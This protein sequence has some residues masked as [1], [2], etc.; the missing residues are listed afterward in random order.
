MINL[1]AI[2]LFGDFSEEALQDLACRLRQCQYS[3]GQT[4]LCAGDAPHEMHIVVQGAVRVELGE[5]AGQSRRRA[6][7][8]A[9]HTFGEMSVLSGNPVSATVV[10]H[11]D[12]TTLA[13]TAEDLSLVLEKEPSLYRRI[14]ALLIERLRHR[15]Q[16]FTS[17]FSSPV[18]VLVLDADS[19][20]DSAFVRAIAKG[21]AHYSPGSQLFDARVGDAATLHARIRRWRNEGSADHFLIVV[22]PAEGFAAVRGMLLAGDAVLRVISRA[23]ARADEHFDAGPADARTVLLDL[24]VSSGQA[25]SWAEAVSPRELAEC[26]G[27]SW[28]RARYP[29]ID[30]LAR[31]ITDREVGVAMSVGAAAG[32]AHLGFLQVLQDCGVPIDFICGSSMGGAVALGFGQ[33][34]EASKAA[35]ALCGLGAAFAKSRGLQMVPRAALVAPRRMQQIADEIFGTRTFAEL[36]LPV[37]VVAADLVAGQRVILDRGPVAQA[38]R[39]TVAIPGLFPPVRVGARILVDGGLV[40][41]V[42]VDLLAGRRCGLRIAAVVLPERPN[43]EQVEAEA[44]GLQR[45]L[46]QPFGFRA[47]L[48]AAWRMLGWWDSAAQAGKA[49]LFIRITT[50][51]GEG[52]DFAA[53][54]RMMEFGRRATLE[55]A[56]GMRDAVGRLFEPGSP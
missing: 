14:S 23:P 6:V 29:R 40:T 51:A 15:T 54:K 7:L 49:D 17:R 56:Q 9:G 32:F 34:G 5:G 22:I 55:Q 11:T 4:I 27:S 43:S 8:A 36:H 52:Y 16:M 1:R 24:P 3:A 30:R 37:A 50:P 10:A 26:D 35:D 53:G 31:F 33:F 42:P 19:P 48:G 2:P 21:V 46:E 12:T 13:I 20:V 38:A 18:A 25:G 39:A 41:R 28:N 45:R 44:D 47:A